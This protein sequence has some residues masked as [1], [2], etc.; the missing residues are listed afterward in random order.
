VR[1][2]D[3]IKILEKNP[4]ALVVVDGSDHSYRQASASHA[5]AE[6][7]GRDP[8]GP[9]AARDLFDHISEYWGPEHM[10]DPPGEV[11]DVV[12]IT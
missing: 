7:F 3:L 5:K 11:I 10:A 4:D 9:R 1:A 12:V 6:A 8:R 2:R